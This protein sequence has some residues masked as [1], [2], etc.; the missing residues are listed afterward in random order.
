MHAWERMQA[1]CMH[2]FVSRIAVGHKGLL[3]PCSLAVLA[4]LQGVQLSVP[5]CNVHLS[6]TTLW[7]HPWFALRRPT[8]RYSACHSTRP[9]MWWSAR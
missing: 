5:H 1:H 4:R 7:L 8:R 3:Y 6:S 9:G 2:V